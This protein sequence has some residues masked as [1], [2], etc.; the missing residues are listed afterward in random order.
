MIE[1]PI[2]K[3]QIVYADPPWSFQRKITGG[4][5][6][7]GASAKYNVMSVDELC[8]IPVDIISSPEGFLFMW[9]IAAMP[10]KAIE[11]VDAWG[12]KLKTMTAFSW[13]KKTVHGKD[14]FGMGHY[15]RQ[16]QEHCLVATKGSPR[17]VSHSVRQNIREVN[18]KHSRKPDA[19]RNSIIQLA[20]DLPR[21]E[22]FA[23]EKIDG[24]DSWGD[25]LNGNT[26]RA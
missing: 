25:E 9:W 3:Y 26:A 8:N 17:V 5:M 6:T 2:M 22:L 24:W 12:F 15:T 10:E 23:R 1:L 13:I 4:S 19:V 14:F 11:V 21:I 18:I 16:Q 7:S 20:G